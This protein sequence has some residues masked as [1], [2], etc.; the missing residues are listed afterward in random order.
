M[1]PVWQ[2]ALFPGAVTGL[3]FL[4]NSRI[5][6]DSRQGAYPSPMALYVSLVWDLFV[7]PI[8]LAAS[9]AF[10]PWIWAVLVFPALLG[11]AMA[12][13]LFSNYVEM[14]ILGLLGILAGVAYS[15]FQIWTYFFAS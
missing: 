3:G 7:L 15:L 11:G 13:G 9:F 1:S 12:G 4:I 6:S 10:L 2:H 5:M 8:T 14:T